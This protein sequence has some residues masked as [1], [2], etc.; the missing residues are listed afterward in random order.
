MKPPTSE[1]VSGVSIFHFLPALLGIFVTHVGR[2][3][4]VAL[5]EVEGSLGSLGCWEPLV[6]S[7]YVKIAGWKICLM[8]KS[9]ISMVISIVF[10][11]FYGKFM[12]HPR[13]LW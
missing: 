2:H 4:V 3:D 11:D 10:N 7:G 1:Q 9:M 6:A 13:F 5:K 8:E 12:K